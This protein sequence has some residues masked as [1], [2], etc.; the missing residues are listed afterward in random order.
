[1]AIGQPTKRLLPS[2]GLIAA[3][4]I[5]GL[6]LYLC[7]MFAMAAA[8]FYTLSFGTGS[9]VALLICLL[10]AGAAAITARRDAADED[11]ADF[12][13]KIRT[14]VFA[15][16]ALQVVLCIFFVAFMPKTVL[17]LPHS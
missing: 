8:G 7:V 11:T 13:R 16:T 2:I 12:H 6:G 17:F 4:L 14:F 15:M 1:M 10:I 9:F 5:T 3:G